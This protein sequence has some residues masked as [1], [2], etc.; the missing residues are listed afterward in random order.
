MRFPLLVVLIFLTSFWACNSFLN[1]DQKEV[2]VAQ[3]DGKK[4]TLSHLEM[5]IPANMEEIDSISFAQKYIE[6]WVKNQLLLD[7]AELNLDKKTQKEIAVMIDNY[8]TSLLLFKYQQMIIQQKMDTIVTEA[9]VEDY[10]NK[11]ADNFKLDSSVIKCIFIQ[12]PKSVHDRYQVSN[13]LKSKSEEDLISLEDYCYQNAKNFDLGDDWKYFG[14]IMAKLPKKIKDADQFLKTSDYIEVTDDLY[15]YYL[16]IQ[17]Y[18]LTNDTIPLLF[19]KSKIKDIILN[20][21]KVKLIEDLENNIYNDAVDQ[22]K[23]IIHTN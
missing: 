22:K 13:W 6:K 9:Q 23:F 12:M 3:V 4:L 21:R 14:S 8:R 1:G 5:S 11:H 7:K 2:V 18:K 15:A 19:V 16:A 20:H 17:D 10:Y